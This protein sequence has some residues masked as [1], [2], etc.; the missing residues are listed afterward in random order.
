[1]AILLVLIRVGDGTNPATNDGPTKK[2]SRIDRKAVMLVVMRSTTVVVVVVVVVV[3]LGVGGIRLR[4]CVCSWSSHGV[5][6]G[7]LSR[8]RCV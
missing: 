1:M 7:L 5:V 8:W 3:L 2:I 6:C 4:I